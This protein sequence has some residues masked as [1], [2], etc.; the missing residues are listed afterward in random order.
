MGAIF[1][2]LNFNMQE[3]VDTSLL[4]RMKE[5]LVHRGA[6]AGSLY[7]KTHVGLG[8]IQN[9]SSHNN[10][11]CLDGNIYEKARWGKFLKQKGRRING[12]NIGDVL[13]GLYEVFGDEFVKKLTGEFALA[14]WDESNKKLIL[15]KDQV[16]TKPLFYWN[17]GTKLLFAS[18][19]KAILED[20]DYERKVNLKALNYFL[21]LRLVPWP[22]TFFEGI[23]CLPP[24]YISICENGD[25]ATK[26][27]W[28]FEYR[29]IE[30]KPESYYIETF[31]HLLKD[32]VKIRLE[33][34][35]VPAAFLSGGLDS[36]SMVALLSMVSSKRIKTFTA[37]FEEERFNEAPNARRVS[38]F[39]GTEHYEVLVKSK[40]MG[41]FLG[42]MI[43]YCEQPFFDSSAI[44]TYYV[45]QLARSQVS[46]VFDS[47]GPDQF[48]AGFPRHAIRLTEILRRAP[49]PPRLCHRLSNIT[50]GFGQSYEENSFI[51]KV[52]YKLNRL[53]IPLAD[54]LILDSPLFSY[55]MKQCVAKW[56]LDE[57]SVL[58][59][60]HHCL[61]HVRDESLLSKILYWDMCHLLHDDLLVKV[62]RMAAPTGLD[63]TM[64]F[65][66]TRLV[67][68]GA[69]IPD[70]LKVRWV[71]G[72][73]ALKFILRKSLGKYLPD[74]VFE[75]EKRGFRIPLA[76]WIK[77]ELKDIVCAV[78]LDDTTLRSHYFN[79]R[80]I[81]QLVTRF[82]KTNTNIGNIP[83]SCDPMAD[84]IWA[85]LV[86][87]LWHR[88]FID[89][90]NSMSE[91]FRISKY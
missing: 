83:L 40:D 86:F 44:A 34:G 62:D 78:L 20:P 53:S 37:A 17:S 4:Q 3:S 9:S 68:L 16:G 52:K 7:C 38:E 87:E 69:E 77:N 76:H 63:I 47:H 32:T 46:V 64:P 56:C 54:R 91:I 45:A 88:T 61:T 13:L 89:R 23:Y 24:G 39:F 2:I 85:L 27:Y 42:D 15:A 30:P 43:W 58:D 28:R 51:A 12:N 36:T 60:V 73:P 72:Q 18:E 90:R 48:L 31:Y 82:Y 71:N 26:P 25:F 81:R 55:D 33:D 74:F 8:I 49:L 22:E 21:H 67:E 29:R 84:Q 35:V 59:F 50:A 11:V 79:G 6:Q 14:L 80:Y 41:K 66:D 10:K 65:L 75:G 57:H 1:G 70:A 19:I 5:Q